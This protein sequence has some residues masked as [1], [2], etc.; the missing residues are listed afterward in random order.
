MAKRRDN[1]MGTI[2]QRENGSWAGRIHEG[3]KADG[4]PKYKFF[5]G[6]TEAEVKRKIREYNR[7]GVRIDAKN[8]TLTEYLDMGQL[9]GQ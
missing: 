7:S 1:G 4:K 6:K 8:I 5:S 2:Y 9:L 3:K